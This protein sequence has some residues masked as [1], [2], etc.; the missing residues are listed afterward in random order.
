MGATAV[1][2]IGKKLC[3]KNDFF[4]GW[5]PCEVRTRTRTRSLCDLNPMLYHCATAP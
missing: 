2:E 1:V 5:Q 4:E 3:V